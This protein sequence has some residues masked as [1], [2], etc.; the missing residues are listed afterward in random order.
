MDNDLKRILQLAG[1]NTLYISEN[2]FE[3]EKENPED[4]VTV[5]VP[6][7]IRLMEYSR[8]DAQTDMDLHDVAEKL[9]ELSTNGE[10]LTMD[11]YDD[12][13]GGQ[14]MGE[15]STG[16]YSAKK[17]AAG[18]D[19]GKPG[20]NFSKIAKKSGGG[21]KGKRIAGAVLKNLRK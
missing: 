9:I 1:A 3:P 5:D 11:H 13:V 17:A 7:L 21:E 12:I 8:E 20:K 15:A 14:K 19:I 18:K 6:L 10:T 4:T 2:D 16:D